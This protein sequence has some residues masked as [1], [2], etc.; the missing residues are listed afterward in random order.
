L[1][2]QEIQPGRHPRSGNK[3]EFLDPKYMNGYT[4]RI[5]ENEVNLMF[6]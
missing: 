5:L 4:P 3:K 1:N 6:P 2:D